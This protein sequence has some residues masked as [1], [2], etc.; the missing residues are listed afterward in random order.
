MACFGYDPKWGRWNGLQFGVY[1]QHNGQDA[2]E[3]FKGDR[4]ADT[5]AVLQQNMAAVWPLFG[6]MCAPTAQCQ[7]PLSPCALAG[8]LDYIFGTDPAQKTAGNFI[9]WV[10]SKLRTAATLRVCTR[11]RFEPRT[12]RNGNLTTVDTSASAGKW[13]HSTGT[14]PAQKTRRLS[15]I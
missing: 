7:L 12:P 1:V 13:K 9:F 6:H 3:R 8:T 2:L 4:T 15:P 10:R 11:V 5:A 14:F